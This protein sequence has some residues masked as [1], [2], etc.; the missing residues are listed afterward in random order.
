MPP[1]KANVE[2]PGDVPLTANTTAKWIAA[3]ASIVI[4]A[5]S[6][7]R[8]AATVRGDI[9]QLKVL[10]T[11]TEHRIQDVDR[12]S[13]ERDARQQK[14]IDKLSERADAADKSYQDTARK[15]DVAVAILEEIK[16]KVG[17]K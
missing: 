11:G 16:Q 15:L 8:Y 13:S 6:L 7:V 12:L 17:N 3:V 10:A 14:Q 4:A 5:T 9:E 2:D 1:H